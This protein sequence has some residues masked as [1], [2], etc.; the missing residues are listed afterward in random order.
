MKAGGRIGMKIYTNQIMTIQIIVDFKC[1]IM[2]ITLT[3]L[4]SERPKLVEFWPFGVQK[5]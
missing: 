2:Q 5:G 1:P 3:L 4:R